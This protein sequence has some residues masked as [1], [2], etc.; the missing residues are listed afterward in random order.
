MHETGNRSVQLVARN[1]EARTEVESFVHQNAR[2]EEIGESHIEVE[3]FVQQVA[4]YE[5]IGELHTEV[6]SFVQQVAR[7]E[8]KNLTDFKYN[9]FLFRTKIRFSH[10][11][12]YNIFMRSTAIRISRFLHRTRNVDIGSGTGNNESILII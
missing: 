5:G 10:N 11:R 2:Y 8:G 4:R 3:S 7:Y 6:E 1:H 9:I 12:Y